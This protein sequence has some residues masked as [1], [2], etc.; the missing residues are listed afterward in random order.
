MD[1]LIKIQDST[2][3]RPWVPI[4]CNEDYWHDDAGFFDYSFRCELRKHIDDP[5]L[6]RMDT[7]GVDLKTMAPFL[8][9]WLFFGTLQENFGESIGMDLNSFATTSSAV[10]TSQQ[11]DGPS[12][13][14]PKG[15]L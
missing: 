14:H 3:P 1:H 11:R 9:A 6:Y 7:D 12:K 15:I 2:I 10:R 13:D 8:Q 4:V 5:D